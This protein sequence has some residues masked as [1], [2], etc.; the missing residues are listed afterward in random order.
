V[1]DSRRLGYLG[2][3]V[4]YVLPWALLTVLASG[5]AFWSITLLSVALLARI[6]LAL[7]VGVGILNDGQVLRDLLLLP[8]RDAFG[9]FFW[10]WSYA[11]NTVVWRGQRFRLCRGHLNPLPPPPS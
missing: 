9:L 5:G 7:L 10:I 2:L 11:S 8:L 6:S 1:R 3:A 4:T